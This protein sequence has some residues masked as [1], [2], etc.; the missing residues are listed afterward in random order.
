MRARGKSEVKAHDVAGE[1]F[2]RP[3]EEVAV[4]PQREGDHG[5]KL[6]LQFLAEID[7]HVAADDQVGADIGRIVER[8]VVGEDDLALQGGRD[9]D[10]GPVH[11]HELGREE[12]LGDG[13]QGRGGEHPLAGRL[14]RAVVHIGGDDLEVAL[15]LGVLAIA[16]E[17][18][19]EGIGLFAGRTA[20]RPD[21]HRF[22]D[23]ALREDARQDF[24][25]QV[26]PGGRVAEEGRGADEEVLRQ[27][28]DLVGVVVDQL[29]VVLEA[30]A[31]RDVDAP[32]RPP[33]QR[34]LLVA[35]EVDVDLARDLRDQL[36]EELV[37]LVDQRGA[38]V[39]VGADVLE[40]AGQ[41][42]HHLARGDD[43]VDEL[44][45]D[46]RVGHAVEIGAARA[47]GHD[48][49]A[50]VLDGA[51]AVAAV[52]AGA[53]QDDAHGALARGLGQ[54]LEEE[55]DR[56]VDLFGRA[57]LDQRETQALVVDR[58]AGRRPLRIELGALD[59]HVPFRRDQVDMAR[60]HRH[61]VAHL[62]HVEGG[63]APE[64]LGHHRLVVGREVLDDDETVGRAGRQVAD[65]RLDRR[66]TAGRSADADQQEGM[67]DAP[68]LAPLL[69]PLG[70]TSPAICPPADVV[71]ECKTQAKRA[72]PN[73]LIQPRRD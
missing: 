42:V 8:I 72:N 60:L 23:V 54:R 26:A 34:A 38:T 48:E 32:R 28:R 36:L 68:Q 46:G 71:A 67:V 25:F 27:A 31:A 11:R 55:V 45:V 50:I 66:K 21:L 35:R 73:R 47:L 12:L 14:Q 17:E 62:D 53:G 49:T 9:V 22:G 63:L 52:G 41:F 65:Q 7:Q 56:V 29:E 39:L 18:E 19:R 70:P 44:G 6:L 33:L 37:G 15:D 40:I 30:L 43:D 16:L 59:H 10:A 2:G 13:R 4:A 69:P 61:V 20:E 3:E 57:A 58:I 1:V 51:D 24:A 64:D 5:Q